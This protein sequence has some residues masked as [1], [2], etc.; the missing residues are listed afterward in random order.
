MG[1]S[2]HERP[3]Y[4]VTKLVAAAVRRAH[5]TPDDLAPGEHWSVEVVRDD[6]SDGIRLV[7]FRALGVTSQG[8]QKTDD[9]LIAG[10]ALR[11][12]SLKGERA[13]IDLILEELAHLAMR[14]R[15]ALR[16]PKG[17]RL[18]SRGRVCHV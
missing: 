3:G 1:I 5:V 18:F 15:Y 17:W 14:M 13:L 10:Q 6:W 8:R 4:D 9:I 12:A 7:G 16:P 11:C 2:F